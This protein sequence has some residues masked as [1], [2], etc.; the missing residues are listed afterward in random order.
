M[1]TR[2]ENHQELEGL[3]VA[4]WIYSKA[5]KTFSYVGPGVNHIFETEIDRITDISQF[6]RI[7]HQDDQVKVLKNLHTFHTSS[8]N[9][10]DFRV[11]TPKGKVKWMR[12]FA[13]SVPGEEENV[14][15]CTCL[16]PKKPIRVLQN[17]N[18]VLGNHLLSHFNSYLI[19]D[20]RGLIL[21]GN[22]YK[23]ESPFKLPGARLE[24]REIK[25]TL[26]PDLVEPLM[27]KL[28]GVKESGSVFSHVEYINL[29]K[30]NYWIEIKVS[31]LDEQSYLVC[32]KN[33]TSLFKR[34]SAVEKFYHISEQSEEM[35][36]VTDVTGT[37]EY[38]NPKFCEVTGYSRT[39]LVGKKVSAIRSGKHSEEFYT[40]LWELILEGKVYRGVI[41]S[42][43]KNGDVFTEEKV[44]TPLFTNGKITNF[45]GTGRDIT[46]KY[47]EEQKNN[48][49]DRLQVTIAEKETKSQTLSLIRSVENERRKIAHDI[50]EG[51]SQMLVVAMNN[52]KSLGEKGLDSEHQLE[53]IDF[54][55]QLISEII[56]DLRGI[57]GDL[58]PSGLFKFGLEPLIRQLAI[59]HQKQEDAAEIRFV[60]NLKHKRFKPEVE[61]NLYRTIEEALK[62]VHRHAQASQIFLRLN[63]RNGELKLRIRDNGTGIN[64]NLLEYKKISTFG[65]LNIEARSKS[66]GAELSLDSKRA[67]GFTLDLKL[68]TKTIQA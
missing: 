44:I 40:R 42:L 66:I 15:G 2:I 16:L 3:N 45:I 22:I 60:S 65:I 19:V 1:I 57:S 11:Q 30:K 25:Q 7:V 61:I 29:R 13:T 34:L 33:I 46:K 51:V 50:H 8:T 41:H 55:N 37:V 56:G 9:V 4:F 20:P 36:V 67:K 38:V 28:A 24:G 59:R 21:D 26:H 62:N 35:I 58:S 14:M 53:K 10:L 18:S 48:K 32:L 12:N 47:R 5:K 64:M 6:R 27:A 63:Y 43:S 23:N 54:V 31:R 17:Q 39:E 68:N 52:L 49:H